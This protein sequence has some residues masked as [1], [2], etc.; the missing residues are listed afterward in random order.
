[1][2]YSI[3]FPTREQHEKPRL[4]REPDYFK[5]LNLDQVFNAI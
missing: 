2:F 3:L 1:M 5:D 4:E